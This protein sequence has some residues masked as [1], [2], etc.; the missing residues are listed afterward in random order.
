[1]AERQK[2]RCVASKQKAPSAAHYVGYVEDGE[3][4]E[5]IMKKFEEM[6]RLVRVHKQQQAAGG[7]A[8]GSGG[9]V[10]R[11]PDSGQAAG[12]SGGGPGLPGVADTAGGFKEDRLQAADGGSGQSHVEAAAA[13]GGFTGGFTEELLLEVFKNTSVYNVRSVIA[14]N[15]VL[16]QHGGAGEPAARRTRCFD[17]D[18]SEAE[19]LL[20]T[21]GQPKY[22][23]V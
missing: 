15:E 21:D 1:M 11:N 17:A 10:D 16:M 14:N 13:A 22:R 20:Q 19:L 9:G 18:F 8:S 2:R 23:W 12:C 5:M 6:E 3:T 7:E 4:T